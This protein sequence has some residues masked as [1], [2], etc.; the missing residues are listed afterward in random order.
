MAC[1]CF[2]PESFPVKSQGEEM[3]YIPEPEPD[4][5]VLAVMRDGF[6]VIPKEDE[7]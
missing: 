4:E 1:P 3:D 2:P 5:P 7:V 6:W